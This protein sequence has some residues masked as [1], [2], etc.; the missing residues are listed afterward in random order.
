VAANLASGAFGFASASVVA[1]QWG[2]AGLGATALAASLITYATTI[3]T[4]GT[5]IY[6]VRTGAA[7]RHHLGELASSVIFIRLCLAVLVFAGI[8]GLT[9]SVPA[10]YDIRILVWLY[11]LSV[12]TI[13]F[14]ISWVPQAIH[15]TNAFAVAT[16]STQGL[17]FL[18]LIGSLVFASDVRAVPM[19]RIA[20]EACVAAGFLYWMQ[21]HVAPIAAAM[22]ARRLW[23][24]LQASAPIG[25]TQLLRGLALGS[26]LI[27]LGLFVEAESLGIYAAAFKIFQLLL[28]L[29]AAYFI[30]LL[31]RI[32]ER[33][34]D[35][36]AMAGE[37]RRSFKEALPAAIIGLSLMAATAGPLLRLLF[38]VKFAGASTSLRVLSIALL[39]NISLRHYRQVLLARGL[40]S[41]DL[42]NSVI[43]G[44]VHVAAKIVLIP[45]MGI[46][47]AAVG[48]LVGE[49]ALL[50]L[51]RRT[52]LQSLASQQIAPLEGSTR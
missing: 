30:I 21:R 36:V 14:D 39:A 43:G 2:P 18:F 38:G 45:A 41:L 27:L 44:L 24:F 6:A 37:L 5:E 51:Q 26:D 19:A 50:V 16:I 29:T 34:H 32:A 3:T 15:R 31:P 11:G 33:S 49:I 13:A 46:A 25:G 9:F 47:G 10:F 42:R 23:Q 28:G 35:N 20:A 48:T 52:A 4:C 17:A 22:P 12:F 1:W 40:Q 8:V 7:G